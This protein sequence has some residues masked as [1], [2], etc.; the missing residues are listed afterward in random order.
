M[1]GL[2][3]GDGGGDDE[4][5]RGRVGD[6]IESKWV[7]V[8]VEVVMVVIVGVMVVIVGVM[9]VI[10]GVMVVIVGVMVVIVGGYRDNGSDSGWLS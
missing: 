10:V 7:V 3:D 9:V 8:L 1:K 4:G 2:Y 6:G 5:G